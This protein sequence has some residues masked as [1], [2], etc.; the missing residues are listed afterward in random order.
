MVGRTVL[1]WAIMAAYAVVGAASPQFMLCFH[2]DGSTQLE[3]AA[4][5]CCET[6]AEPN[7]QDCTDGCGESSSAPCP[8]DRCQD[9]PLLVL[10]PPAS[11][12]AP[13]LDL[14]ASVIDPGFAEGA[15]VIPH[16]PA[17]PANHSSHSRDHP[18]ESGA[19]EFLRTVIL[20]L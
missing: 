13:A 10:S 19:R 8:D 20:R 11:S 5:R 17:A 3:L 4:L 18:P 2:E 6:P 15:G 12:V 16:A 14:S 7:D 1:G 9:A